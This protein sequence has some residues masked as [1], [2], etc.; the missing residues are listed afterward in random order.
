M[1]ILK[2]LLFLLLCGMFS[3]IVVITSIV[4]IIFT[5][6]LYIIDAIYWI[7]TGKYPKF[8]TVGYKCIK[9]FDGIPNYL[10]EKLL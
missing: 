10:E 6:L 5:P 7:V 8:D 4:L 9:I 3:I 2:R 1:K